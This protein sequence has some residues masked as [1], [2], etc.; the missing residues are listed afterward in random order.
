MSYCR[1]IGERKCTHTH[2]N[3]ACFSIFSGVFSLV[4]FSPVHSH[5]VYS[6]AHCRNCKTV[7]ITK[8][9]CLV[10][11]PL[12]CAPLPL[13]LLRPPSFVVFLLLHFAYA[14]LYVRRCV[15]L[16]CAQAI[17]AVARSL[18]SATWYSADWCADLTDAH[19]LPSCFAACTRV[20]W[21]HWSIFNFEDEQCVDHAR[22][23]TRLLGVTLSGA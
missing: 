16:W 5:C 10:R 18:A 6:K 2:V 4:L 3:N 23:P 19:S 11:T 7:P 1:C 20:L 17:S 21:R 15:A 13:R 9:I 12:P 22:E 8:A 14:R